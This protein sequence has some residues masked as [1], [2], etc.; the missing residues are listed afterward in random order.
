MSLFI[1]IVLS[2]FLFALCNL[3]ECEG[4]AF[5]SCFLG[6]KLF[7]KKMVETRGN[8]NLA[9]RVVSDAGLLSPRDLSKA[10][11]RCCKWLTRL[12]KHLSPLDAYSTKPDMH[13]PL[14]LI[15]LNAGVQTGV[16]PFALRQ[17]LLA[18]TQLAED[19]FNI[20]F[21]SALPFAL[22]CPT[23]S[24]GLQVS[25]ATCVYEVEVP[26]DRG[27][28]LVYMV[29]DLNLWMSGSSPGRSS[30]LLY[31]F[32]C[33]ADLVFDA[34]RH[35]FQP[36]T[37][38]VERLLHSGA[39]TEEN[40]ADDTA[41]CSCVAVKEVPGLYVVMDFIT[42]EEHDAIW[43]EL[44]G[45]NASTLEVE[46][47]AR[48]SVAHFNRRF[49]YG[50]NQLGV[51][52][53]SVNAKPLFYDWMHRRLRNADSA[54]KVQNYPAVAEAFSCDQLTVNFYNYAETDVS[55]PGIAHHVDG[56]T[57][58]M[59]C[60]FIVSL[61][62]H[63]VLEFSRH[64]RPPEMVAPT[65][66]FVAPR[67]LLLMTGEARYAWTHCIAEKRVDFV[68]DRVPALRRGDRVS[69]TWR[70][71]RE[72]PHRRVDCMFKELCDGE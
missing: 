57:P 25:F 51:P 61:G 28:A 49:Y 50:V 26:M 21:S 43:S 62:S 72:G 42:Q 29:P 66:V 15:A 69:L 44:K 30:C 9:C 35:A 52:G 5:F 63:T 70:R 33:R 37:I 24:A 34:L 60:V 65:G 11:S 10:R 54:R 58:F 8:N 14:G 41:V 64:D 45:K 32:C 48:R 67:S 16:S 18:H 36:P 17:A 19:A 4:R 1:V 46:A 55:A 3:E 20:C 7:E 23:A 59:D 71:G 6:G 40:S 68:S 22:V 56:H 53:E 38:G 12:A 47:L 39:V 27:P 2:L 31:L 13:K